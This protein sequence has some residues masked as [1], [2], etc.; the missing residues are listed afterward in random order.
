MARN[1]EQP[2]AVAEPGTAVADPAPLGLAAFGVTTLL[3]SL[4]NAGILATST[5]VGVMS[6]AI[7]FGGLSQFVAGMWAFRRNNTFAATAFTSYGAFWLSFFLLV[8]VFIPQMKTATPSDIGN[9]VGTYLLAWGIFTAYMTVAAL[10]AARAVLIV[11]VLLTLTFVVL[12]I[13]EYAVS[14]TIHK[15]GG[16]VGIATAAAAMY[17]SFGDVVNASFGRRV[18]PT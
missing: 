17:A 11:F 9:F 15:A 8:L 18:L 1:F 13:G 14:D 6:L 3:L 10:R 7:T 16:Y 5:T 4:I 12:A 2:A